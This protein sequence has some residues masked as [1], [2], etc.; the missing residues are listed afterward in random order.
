VSASHLAT[1]SVHQKLPAA[2]AFRA[3]IHGALATR[4]LWNDAR[5]LVGTGILL[6]LVFLAIIGPRF[7]PDPLMPDPEVILEPPSLAHPMG[8][9]NFGRSVLARVIAGAQLDLQIALFVASLALVAGSLIGALSGFFA[10]VIDEVLMRL[11]D[12]LQSFPAFLLALSITAMLGNDTR[13]VAIAIAVAYTPYFVRIVRGEMLAARVAP[14]AL[15]ARAVG[16]PPLRIMWYHLLPNCLGP[17]VV[18]FTLCLGWSILDAAGLSYLGMGIRP[19][20]AEWGV[21]VAEGAQFVNSGHWW[22][23]VFPGLTILLAVLS[24]NLLGDRLRELLH[25]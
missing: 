1:A 6:A 5:S 17:A 10:G 8:T 3:I 2:G 4:L 16:N 7:T 18:Q 22:I 11:V 14:Y 12:I 24:F 19:P 20:T 15:A 21:L 13:N 25:G 9:D 23:S